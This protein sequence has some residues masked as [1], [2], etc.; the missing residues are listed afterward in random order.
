[1]TTTPQQVRD[2]LDSDMVRLGLTEA[3]LA[4]RVGVSQ[5][6]VNKWR[7]IGVIPMRSYD[8]V[9]EALGRDS[10][11]AQIGETGMYEASRERRRLLAQAVADGRLT[12]QQATIISLKGLP[13]PGVHVRDLRRVRYAVPIV[14]T[15]PED[16]PGSQLLEGA[17]QRIEA[18]V[19]SLGAAARDHAGP[20]KVL[21]QGM[22]YVQITHPKATALVVALPERSMPTTMA[23]MVLKLLIAARET[24]TSA[25]VV[26]L[27]ADDVQAQRA[28]HVY[29][30]VYDAAVLGLDVL[31]HTDPERAA[32]HLEQV[33]LRSSIAVPQ[34]HTAEEID[35]EALTEL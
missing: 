35:E 5:Q 32:Q 30:R 23:A 16:K 22:A 29:R 27:A 3:E 8:V 24:R 34:A 12:E 1:M 11:V 33:A 15:N 7:R 10:A 21:P 19:A 2:A 17:Q 20:I 4:R 6:A 13:E 26:L 9:V 31:T 25:H 14:E 28:S 18:F